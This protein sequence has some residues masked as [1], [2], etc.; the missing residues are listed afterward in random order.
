MPDTAVE[1]VQRNAR[2]GT[3][4][5]PC[6][7][8]LRVAS[9]RAPENGD[10]RRHGAAG[11][12]RR[13]QPQVWQLADPNVRPVRSR[14]GVR[15]RL[16]LLT[17]VVLSGSVRAD[18]TRGGEDSGQTGRLDGLRA[19]ITGAA[20]S[21]SEATARSSAAEG[22]AA[23]LADIDDDRGGRIA[24]ELGDRCRYVHADVSQEGAV[25]AEVAATAAFV[26]WTGPG[27][28]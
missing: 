1:A 12:R 13:V 21:I 9:R 19:V 20:S 18:I 14:G 7:C 6:C 16:A 11:C 8:L 23:V 10:S 15:P 28:L 24:G 5:R 26:A 25:D 3:K 4:Q 27:R 2:G 22:A 17:G